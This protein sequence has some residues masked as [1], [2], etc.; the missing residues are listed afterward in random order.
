[1]L[2]GRDII[3]LLHLKCSCKDSTECSCASLVHEIIQVPWPTFGWL[4]H[5]YSATMGPV[6]KA[7]AVCSRP[8]SPT[9][10][11]NCHPC[12]TERVLRSLCVGRRS[13][14]RGQLP[15]I[16][17]EA[18][19]PLNPPFHPPSQ[20][21]RSPPLPPSLLF[22]AIQDWWC[23]P[24]PAGKLL[25]WGPSDRAWKVG[26]PSPKLKV[27]LLKTMAAYWDHPYGVDVY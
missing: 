14:L 2:S 26:S 15:S 6:C 1:M 3:M 12:T 11:T 17:S 23:G 25:L 8:S 27:D 4:V 20:M 18:C 24:K 7:T 21:L 16:R 9:S 22:S 10:P 13:P 19:D 5:I